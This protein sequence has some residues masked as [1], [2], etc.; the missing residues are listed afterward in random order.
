M[1]I[2]R[3]TSAIQRR[4]ALNQPAFIAYMM[5][6]DPDPETSFE[7]ALALADA[8]ADII[9]V[10]APFTDPMADGP[11]IQRAAQRSLRSGGSLLSALSLAARLRAARPGTGIV[12]MGY[13][14][15]IHTLGWKRFAALAADAGVDG[16]ITVDLPPEEDRPLREVLAAQHIA[17]IRLATPTTDASRMRIIA[18]GAAG[19]LYYVS[20]A[21]VT[22]AGVGA[23]AD[24]RGGVAQAR[25]ISGLPVAV[26]F[27][28]RTPEQ[29]ARFGAFADAVVVGSALVDEIAAATD[30]GDPKSAVKRISVVA[31]SLSNAL[32]SARV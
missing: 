4:S 20:V 22:G 1:P 3:L 16:A 24:I 11:S 30:A 7:I 19:F 26:G 29:A 21:G 12:I 2:D 23:E 9:E 14:N 31:R 32:S 5:A 28:V 18:D 6:D 17:H 27:G 8:G 25:D 15:P 10:G 13:A